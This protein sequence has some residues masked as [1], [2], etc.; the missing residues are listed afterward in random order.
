MEVVAGLLRD[1]ARSFVLTTH[2]NADG[3]A[4]GSMLGLGR[5]LRAAGRTVHYWHFDAVPV[6]D[7]LA[8]LLEAGERISHDAHVGGATLIAL[9]CATAGRMGEVEPSSLGSPVINID[10][11]HDNTRFGDVDLVV[12]D[13]SS[14]AEIVATLLQTA[15]IPLTESIA[16]PLY[17]GIVTDTGRFGYANVA[18]ATLRIAADLV[19]AGADIPAICRSLY[20]ET[21]LGATRLLGAALTGVRLIADGRVA[22]ASLNQ[23][24][25]AEAGS[26]SSDGAVEALRSIQGVEVAAVLRSV[27]VDDRQWRISM[28]AS[29]SEVDVSAV[30]RERSGGGHRA[31]AG[32]TADGDLA[33]VL[34]WLEPALTA[35]LSEQ[36]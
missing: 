6:R 8:F 31:A 25:L 22:L 27:S 36:R 17:V 9:D 24:A 29:S 32:C 4:I 2:T 11:H 26:D 34:G 19:A 5:A 23:A 3:D 33:A 20:E 7:D 13:A 12:D 21:P 1:P 18:P 30:A 16:T 10:H 14:T 28:R 15:G 35:A